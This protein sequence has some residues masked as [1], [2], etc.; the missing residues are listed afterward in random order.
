MKE[1]SGPAR[2]RLAATPNQ[3][4]STLAPGDDCDSCRILRAGILTALDA[5]GDGDSG[6]A[7]AALDGALEGP[8]SHRLRCPACTFR[9]DWPGELEGHIY[10][11]HPLLL[12]E[13]D[14]AA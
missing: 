3:M 9:A 2:S 5:L 14:R 4:P 7:V 11:W 10:R 13:E 8:P 1:Q 6:Y 12:V